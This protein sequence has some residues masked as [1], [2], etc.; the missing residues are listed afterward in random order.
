MIVKRKIMWSLIGKVDPNK[1]YSRLQENPELKNKVQYFNP[2]NP[3]YNGVA[4][5][6]LTPFD[7]IKI[8]KKIKSI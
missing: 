5:S 2:L 7:G 6:M 4:L 8:D 3:G 1:L